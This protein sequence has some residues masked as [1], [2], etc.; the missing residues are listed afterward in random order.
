MITKYKPNYV[1]W[2]IT[3]KC[4]AKC[5]HCG[6][7]CVS[8]EKPDELT[9]DECLKI[10][11]DL[12]ELGTRTIVLSGGDPL[13][14]KDFPIL[15]REIKKFG[16]KL[17]FIT[18]GI[19]LNDEMIEI[20]KEL[21]P[22][23]FGIS[24]DGAEGY[25][26]DYIRGHKGCFSHALDALINLS[27]S[28]VV[29]SVITTV[30]KLNYP[31]L[32]MLRKIIPILGVG[33]WQIQYA[34]LIG[35]M[36]QNCMITEAQ[37]KKMVEFIWQTKQLYGPKYNV[38]GSDIAGYMTDL[39]VKAGMSWKGCR[40]GLSV[41]GLGSDGTVRGCLSQQM[42]KY[43]E[44]NI[45]ECSLKDIWNNKEAFA[46][47]RKFDINTLGGYCK[48]CEHAEIC[49]G[50]CSRSATNRSDCRCASY[51]LHKIDKLGFSNEYNAKTYFSKDEIAKL[52]NPIKKLPK[53]FYELY[54]PIEDILSINW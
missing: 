51:C 24:L 4:N 26:H 6:S 36:D 5:I 54:E 35:R 31:Q 43:I 48:E 10:I 12:H 33:A 8:K 32:P 34:D 50:G 47:N 7:D 46:Y 39:S 18:N 16:I 29:P 30:H 41:L 22:R 38:T 17:E 20:I 45:R 40:A 3:W 15:A 21:K 37:F 44:G 25:I 28:G 19:A 9:T 11:S 14:R 53:E 2:E 1:V 23:A 13:L 52:Y 42:D 27:K 49:K